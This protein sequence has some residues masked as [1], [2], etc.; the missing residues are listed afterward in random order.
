MIVTLDSF[1]IP[2]ICSLIIK[3]EFKRT[4]LQFPDEFLSLSVPIYKKF[5]EILKNQTQ[6]YM[7]ID[8]SY[9]SSIDDISAQ[10]VNSDL[11]VY[12]GDDLSSSGVIPVIVAPPNKSL[13]LCKLMENLE[14]IQTSYL[15]ELKCD[16]Y[17]L[18]ILYEPGYFKQL[19]ESIEILINGLN[20]NSDM[21]YLAKLPPYADLS[22]WSSSTTDLNNNFEIV[23]GLLIPSKLLKDENSR[24]WY[25]GDKNSQ[26][27]NIKLMLSDKSI[28]LYSPSLTCSELSQGNNSKIF[29]ERYGGV[30]KVKD[31]EIIGII[32]G[33]MGLTGDLTNNLISR[34]QKLITASG[35]KHYTF[36]M[37]RLNEAKLCNF[38]EIDLYCL[39]AND[40]S[41]L[42][43]PKTFHV[44]VVT[45]FE[46]ELGLGAHE[47]ESIYLTS[48]SNL[49]RNNDTQNLCAKVEIHNKQSD[50]NSEE[51]YLNKTSL[52]D[53]NELNSSLVLQND[54]SKVINCFSVAG[55]QFSQRDYQGLT[56]EIPGEKDLKIKK[57]LFGTASGYNNLN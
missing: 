50:D 57:G 14:S 53:S 34:L 1:D 33:S 11:L 8:S 38:S 23:G 45:P 42:I 24:F 51:E 19:N 46:L 52:S 20:L 41:A 25:I 43:K 32:V 27:D 48:S 36:V 22:N 3:H 15:R 28:M 17:R 31:A 7:T 18:I 21:L 47:W 12:F 30:S 56:Y 26:V 6:L 40:D 44:P 35:K 13:E 2:Q 37:G 9:G 4:V 49:Y 29:F 16:R 54:Q 39:I 10:H 5:D 55:N